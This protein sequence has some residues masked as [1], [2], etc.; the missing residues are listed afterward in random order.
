[1]NLKEKLAQSRKFNIK[2]EVVMKSLPKSPVLALL[3]V[4]A[5]GYGVYEYLQGFGLTAIGAAVVG[6]LA[7]NQA[8]NRINDAISQKMRKG[9]EDFVNQT[10]QKLENLLEKVQQKKDVQAEEV[11]EEE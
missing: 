7:A 2:E 9:A 6:S 8:E 1:M 4:A 5:I 11:K 3:E 10:Q